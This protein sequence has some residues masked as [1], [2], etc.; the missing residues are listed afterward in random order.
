M[1]LYNASYNN[2]VNWFLGCYEPADGCGHGF[3]R[4]VPSYYITA[5]GL[6]VKRGF[7]GTI[8]QWLAS[9][10]GANGDTPCIGAN[11]NWWISGTDTGVAAGYR[12]AVIP[13]GVLYGDV[14]GDGEVGARDSRLLSLYLAGQAT[15]AELRLELADVNA[16]GVVDEADVEL[17]VAVAAG[18]AEGFDAGV[19]AN[20]TADGDYFYYDLTVGGITEGMAVTLMATGIEI[21]K[22]ESHEGYIRLFVTE[23]PKAD[24][25]YSLHFDNACVKTVNGV[26]PDENGNVVVEGGVGNGVKAVSVSEGA[27]GTITMINTLAEGV[28]ILALTPD[29]DG[30]PGKLTYNG[31]EIPISWVVS[32]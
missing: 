16:D 31:K 19:Y 32:G 3:R 23:V 1:Q 6:A 20:W 14:D 10:R 22:T 12:G 21:V 28:E 17:I 8:D 27:D 24:A 26:K 5:Y 11:G 9:L 4:R 2:F 15:E 30:N 13:A 18:T 7:E 29:A 25:P